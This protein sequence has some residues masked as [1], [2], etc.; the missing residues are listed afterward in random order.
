MKLG[1]QHFHFDLEELLEPVTENQK[2]NQTK[3]HELSEKKHQ[4]YVIL[5]ELQ[6]RQTK[7]RQA[8]YNTVVIF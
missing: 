7:T 6:H 3:Q 5:L 8:H 2:Q 1:K 4:H